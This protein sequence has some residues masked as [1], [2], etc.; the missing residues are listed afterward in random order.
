MAKLTIKEIEATK[1]VR[2]TFEESKWVVL[3]Y[4]ETDYIY[5]VEFEGSESDDNATILAKTHV[6]LLQVEKYEPAVILQ[7]IIREDLNGLN[8]LYN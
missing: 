7:P 3:V 4:D 8:P 2:A 6:V 1:V 5:R